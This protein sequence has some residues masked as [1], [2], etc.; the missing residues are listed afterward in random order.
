MTFK[1]IFDQVHQTLL[2][3]ETFNPGN[4]KLRRIIYNAYEQLLQESTNSESQDHPF[5]GYYQRHTN[6]INSLESVA[7]RKFLGI[8][9]IP[10]QPLESIWVMLYALSSFKDETVKLPPHWKILRIAVELSFP[11]LSRRNKFWGYVSLSLG[12]CL[13]VFMRNNLLHSLS[14][15]LCILGFI[16]PFSFTLVSWLW[17]LTEILVLLLILRYISWK[18]CKCIEIRSRHQDLESL[19]SEE[20]QEFAN[21][22]IP[23]FLRS[24]QKEIFGRRSQFWT[25]CIKC[26]TFSLAFWFAFHDYIWPSLTLPLRI[27]FG[28]SNF[29]SLSNTFSILTTE[30]PLISV[31]FLSLYLVCK[32]DNYDRKKLHRSLE[33][34][35]RQHLGFGM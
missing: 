19:T 6:Y 14:G 8:L 33:R 13:S 30:V 20:V 17:C 28:D 25:K 3:T 7:L 27:L 5:F 31:Y 2:K 11:M 18:I 1:R 23:G 22:I 29:W 9:L 15:I 24:R 21:S 16:L 4:N 10:V 12:T 32:L 34:D 35:L 26:L